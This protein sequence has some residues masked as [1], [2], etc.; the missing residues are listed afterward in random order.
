M[1]NTKT[2]R[3]EKQMI[4]LTT[5]QRAKLK[6]LYESM[7]ARTISSVVGQLIDDADETSIVVPTVK[8]RRKW[9]RKAKATT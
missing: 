8:L 2:E 7:R 1:E 9:Q 5:A 6:R 3:L 4:Y